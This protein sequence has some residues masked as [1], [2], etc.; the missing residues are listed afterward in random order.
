MTTNVAL[1]S[2]D[3]SFNRRPSRHV[4]HIY[5]VITQ[6]FDIYLRPVRVLIITQQCDDRSNRCELGLTRLI[7]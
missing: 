2:I 7:G 1:D 5:E 6:C 4:I 3:R